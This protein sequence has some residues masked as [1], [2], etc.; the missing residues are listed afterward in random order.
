MIKISTAII[1]S[2]FLSG[3]F[4][5][6]EKE[7]SSSYQP[8]KLKIDY[9]SNKPVSSLEIPPDLTS[10]DM[11]NSFRLSEI[12]SDINENFV[13]FS[14][15]QQEFKKV[16]AE[17]V[18]IQVK[19]YGQQRWL[20]IDK[21]PEEVWQLSKEFLKLQGFVLEKEDKKIGILETNYLENRPDIPDESLGF[22][23]SMIGRALDQTYTFATVDKYRIRIEPVMN[24]KQTELFLTLNSLEEIIDPR[25]SDPDRKGETT[26]KPKQKDLVLETEMLYRLMVYLGGEDIKNKV[27]NPKE[28]MFVDATVNEAINGY[29]KLTYNLNLLDSW[30]QFSWALDQNNI[31]I[32]DKD[33]SEKAI[34]I[35][36]ARTSDKGIMSRIFGEEAISKKYQILFKEAEKNKT[37]VYFNDI[38]EENEK[39]T[40]EFS[41]DFF[42]AIANSYKK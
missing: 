28:E 27:L 24:Y 4:S 21:S 13:S 26:W 19:K 22:I 20:L 37:E 31:V 9:Y 10:P 23:R 18:G 35:V 33:L 7:D 11:Q 29:A 38:S 15:Q 2:I 36:S 3:C 8:G 14:D 1:I 41:Y 25:I 32:E 39:E 6:E 17:P 5:Q 42:S 34:Y 12:V 16:L 30:N 40:K